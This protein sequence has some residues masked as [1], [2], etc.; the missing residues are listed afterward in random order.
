MR[1]FK[2]ITNVNG[3]ED[4]CKFISNTAKAFNTTEAV[5]IKSLLQSAEQE[6]FH[7]AVKY[8]STLPND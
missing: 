5:I 7:A 6:T 8:F 4:D 2:L 3:F 1:K